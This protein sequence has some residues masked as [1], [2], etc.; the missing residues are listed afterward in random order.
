MAKKLLVIW[1]DFSVFMHSFSH[2]MD[3]PSDS[4]LLHVII[5]VSVL[6]HECVL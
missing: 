1:N 6:G 5:G 3:Y 4:L 2:V